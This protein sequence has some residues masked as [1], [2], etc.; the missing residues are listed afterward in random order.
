VNV[1]VA[2]CAG[3]ASITP[4]LRAAPAVATA[5]LVSMFLVIAGISLLDLIMSNFT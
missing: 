5:N 2:A 3:L 4:K 1:K